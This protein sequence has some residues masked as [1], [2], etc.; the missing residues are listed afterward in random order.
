[1]GRKRGSKES[2]ISF[3]SKEKNKKASEYLRKGYRVSEVAKLTDLH[4]NT[5]SKIK[6]LGLK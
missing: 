3:L 1:M 6:K 4:I 5:V 2:L